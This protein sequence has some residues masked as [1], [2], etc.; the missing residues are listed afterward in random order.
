MTLHEDDGNGAEVDQ[1]RRRRRGEDLEHALLDAAWEEFKAVGFYDLTIDAV[2]QRAGTSRAVIYRRWPGKVELVAAAARHVIL[3][4]RGP[5]PAPTGSLRG[6]LIG[7]MAWANRTDVR[8]LIEATQHVGTYLAAEGLTLSDSRQLFL[9][10]RPTKSLSPIELA[11]ERGEIDPRNVTPRIASLPFDLFRHEVIL[12][13]QP[14]SEQT[15]LEIVDDIV[16]P[17]LTR[18]RDDAEG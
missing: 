7:L 8:T 3:K 18:K 5:A 4:G 17:L 16:L 11:I 15:I 9:Q 12:N 2:A 14:L 1:T 6:D 10:G 13:A